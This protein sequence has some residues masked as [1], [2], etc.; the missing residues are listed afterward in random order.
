MMPLLA[1]AFAYFG[2]STLALAMPRHFQQLTGSKPVPWQKRGLA[3]TGWSLLGVSIIPCI[4]H[5]K[6]V[7]GVTA[8]V[9]ILMIAS[10]SV[11]LTLT[12][13]KRPALASFLVAPLVFTL[14]FLL[15]SITGI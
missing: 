13:T 5:W 15:P 10:V 4:L 2:F 7:F 8:W 1:L 3:L 11:V 6:I 14:T 12:Y 9:G